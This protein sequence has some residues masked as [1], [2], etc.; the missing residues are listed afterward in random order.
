VRGGQSTLEVFDGAEEER[1]LY[2]VD[3]YSWRE[4]QAAMAKLFA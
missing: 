1:P 3:E 2:A 4:L